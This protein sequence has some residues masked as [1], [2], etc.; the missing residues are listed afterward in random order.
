MSA[1]SGPQRRGHREQRDAYQSRIGQQSPPFDRTKH[2]S[3]Y[4]WKPRQPIDNGRIRH[5]GAGREDGREHHRDRRSESRDSGC[6][7]PTRRPERAQSREPRMQSEADGKDPREWEK[8][9][10]QVWRVQRASSGIGKMRSAPELVW[11]PQRNCSLGQ[12]PRAEALLRQD[13]PRRRAD[14]LPRREAEE[15]GRQKRDYCQEGECE[16]VARHC[17]ESVCRTANIISTNAV[18]RAVHTRTNSVGNVGPDVL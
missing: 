5:L 8:P 3:E 10:E 15:R 6:T 1:S 16:T 17:R 7:E 12:R 11:I 14:R 2:Q 18:S 9:K 4:Q 13:N